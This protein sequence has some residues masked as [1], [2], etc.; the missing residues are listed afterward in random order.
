MTVAVFLGFAESSLFLC[1]HPS[2]DGAGGFMFSGSPSV[3]AYVCHGCS[4]RAVSAGAGL[5]SSSCFVLFFHIV[6]FS[7][8]GSSSG[9][10]EHVFVSFC[11]VYVI[12]VRSL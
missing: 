7:E 2:L 10:F 3:C 8:A 11:K 9:V 5:P 6:F 1:P 12:L 4:A